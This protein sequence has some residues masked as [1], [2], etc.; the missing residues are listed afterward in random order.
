MGSFSEILKN[1]LNGNRTALAR[2]ITLLESQSINSQFLRN[3]LDFIRQLNDAHYDRKPNT[4]R[5]GISGAPG[6]GK[7]TFIESF[8]MFLTEQVSKKV[9]V[10]AVDPSSA[11]RG[12][13]ILADK[14]RMPRLTQCS[15]A[16]IRP[17][18][19]RLHFGGVTQSTGETILLCEAAGY[20][21]V[22]VETVGV[23]Q[24][25]YEVHDLCDIFVLL[26]APASG[27]ELQG[28]KK[29]IVEMANVILITKYDGDLIIP[30]RRMRGEI[31]SAT[32]YIRYNERPSVLCVSAKTNIGI[33]DTW[34]EIDAKVNQNPTLKEAKRQEKRGRLLKVSLINELFNLLNRTLENEDY[35]SRLINNPKTSI[36]EVVQNII[37]HDLYQALDKIKKSN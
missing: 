16:F 18:P 6:A 24:S 21:V 5:I 17:S 30:A 26:V 37:H 27:D 29:G 23:G 8:G 12:G 35:E 19:S 11:I 7:S 9:A 1:V 34:K 3:R 33:E 25:E 32:K 36:Y 15:N 22:I 20:D 31:R 10:L 14:T 4:I 13:S 2:A 28:I